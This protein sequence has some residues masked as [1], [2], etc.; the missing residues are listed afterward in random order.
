LTT[1]QPPN[2]DYA[3]AALAHAGRTPYFLFLH[4]NTGTHHF[5][6]GDDIISSG[7]I[8]VR[9][10]R[11]MDADITVYGTDNCKETQRT[12]AFL[13]SRGTPYTYINLDEDPTG[14]EMVKKEND[15]KRRTPL[16]RVCVGTECR[17]L[18]APSDEDLKAA[19]LDIE[20]MGEAA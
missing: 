4:H 17:V 12:R 19:L 7:G 8:C 14:D 5:S 6:G 11:A 18:R 20:A 2:A 16:V 3:V 15:G 10:R 9:E 1:G 13:D